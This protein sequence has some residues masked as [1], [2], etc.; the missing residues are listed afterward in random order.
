MEGS[1]GLPA[2]FSAKVTPLYAYGFPW[3]TVRQA[4]AG[5]PLQ[6]LR[7]EAVRPADRGVRVVVRPE[8]AEAAVHPDLVADRA[9]YDDH[10]GH[11]RRA[12]LSRCDPAGGERENYREVLRLRAGHDGIDRDLLH[13]G[14]PTV[15]GTRSGVSTTSSS[16][17]WLV[18]VSMLHPLLGGSTIGKKS[19][20]P[21]SRKRCCSF[22]P[23]PARRPFGVERSYSTPQSPPASARVRLRHHRHERAPW[24]VVA[25]D[26]GPQLRSPLLEDRC[27][28]NARRA[29]A[30]RGPGPPTPP[31]GRKRLRAPRRRERRTRFELFA[32]P[33][34]SG[35]HML[36]KPTPRMAASPFVRYR[37]Q[38]SGSGLC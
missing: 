20:Q 29:R 30:S 38:S 8:R 13:G 37:S 21:L 16:R 18:P 33:E 24:R 12:A 9:I 32:W 17:S 31:G 35:A 22:P 14:T 15:R 36:Q 27:G 7:E 25:L 5:A 23:C 28:T 2:S 6:I 10:V 11:R 19:V 1:Q 3:A 26:V 34:T 4:R